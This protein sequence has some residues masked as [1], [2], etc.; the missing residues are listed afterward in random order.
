MLDI[1]RWLIRDLKVDQV[2]AVVRR[3]P[4]EVKFDKKEME[5]VVANLD[6][7]ALDVEIAR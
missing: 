4:A 5:S 1:A 3:G 6:Q 2:I 7:K